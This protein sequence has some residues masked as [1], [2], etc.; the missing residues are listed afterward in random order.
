MN[1]LSTNNVIVNFAAFGV[2]ATSISSV[3]VQGCYSFSYGGTY[4]YNAPVT[5]GKYN[6][7]AI[8]NGYAVFTNLL[9]GVPYTITLSGYST[10]AT[11]FTI[12]ATTQPDGNGNISAYTWVGSYLANSRT[13]TWANPAVTNYLIGVG[14]TNAV[15]TNGT[16]VIIGQ[17]LYLNADTNGA[18]AAV[19]ALLGTAAYSN[20]AAFALSGSVVTN[21]SQLPSMDM[22]GR[23]PFGFSGTGNTNFNSSSGMALIVPSNTNRFSYWTPTSLY[24]FGVNTISGVGGLASGDYAGIF[25]NNSGSQG[26]V[27]PELYLK[28]DQSYFQLVK[29]DGSTIAARI[30]TNGFSGN[31]SSLTGLMSANSSTYST[32][33]VGASVTLTGTNGASTASFTTAGVLKLNLQTNTTTSGGVTTND[34]RTLNLTNAANQFGGN[35]NGS[36]SQLSSD[37][38]TISSDGFGNLY[39]GGTLATSNNII[40][41]GAGNLIVNTLDNGGGITIQGYVPNVA[42]SLYPQGDGGIKWQ[43]F[44]TDN[45]SG[46]SGG[47]FLFNP[48]GYPPVA[49]Y[50]PNGGA[51]YGSYASSPA[52]LSG[53]LFD[54]VSVGT[55]VQAAKL[56]VGG[57]VH[58]TGNYTNDATI[59]AATGL[60]EQSKDVA[61]HLTTSAVTSGTVTASTAYWNETVYLSSGSTITSITIAL[62]SSTT[63]VGQIY[64]IHSKSIVT[65]LTVTGGS[66]ADAAVITMT[67]GQTIAY[68]VQGTSGAYIRIQ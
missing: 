32:N 9:C 33:L 13:F 1:G 43:F 18:A 7:P 39:V 57:T 31:G 19:Q 50:N 35:F 60:K 65:T 24:V 68:Q 28:G 66:F 5:L 56:E 37:N 23:L 36:L 45:D 48:Y 51:A 11:N 62:P 67:A 49:A 59:Y 14:A 41:D 46:Y 10:Y 54:S 16:S 27:Q 8:T 22:T 30:D 29:S 25:V 52:P 53:A 63:L 12:P 47:E 20:A 42:L 40:D 2:P 61:P 21:F 38:G 4:Y 44:S 6:Y 3:T 17:T 58:S 34:Q 64:R 15:T 55:T 26:S